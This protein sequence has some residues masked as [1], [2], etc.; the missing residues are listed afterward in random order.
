MRSRSTRAT[1]A[2]CRWRHSGRCVKL[3]L[4]KA[5]YGRPHWDRL[6]VGDKL[7]NI[8]IDWT[9]W[10]DEA[11]ETE[12]RNAPYGHD[13]HQMA[14]AMGQHWGSNLERSIKAR[15]QASRIDTSNP[16]DEDDEITMG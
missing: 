14:G 1:C 8:A 10:V 6:V 7:S 13:V 12:V 4:A 5:E 2:V 11:E 9:S 15:Q 3:D 16:D